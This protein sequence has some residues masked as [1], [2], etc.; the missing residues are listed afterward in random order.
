MIPQGT[1]HLKILIPPPQRGGG[2][3]PRSFGEKA[4]KKENRK[5]GKCVGKRQK[6][7]DKERMEATG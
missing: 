5:G 3:I 2:N 1:I 7:E 4:I 6:G